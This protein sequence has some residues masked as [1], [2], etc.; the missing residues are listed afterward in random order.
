MRPFRGRRASTPAFWGSRGPQDEERTRGKGTGC[1]ASSAGSGGKASSCGGGPHEAER[2]RGASTGRAGGAERSRRPEARGGG[3]SMLARSSCASCSRASSSTADREHLPPDLE[4]QAAAVAPGPGCGAGE[5]GASLRLMAATTSSTKLKGHGVS[6]SSILA[7][8]CHAADT[9]ADAITGES[10]SGGD[11]AAEV[12]ALPN[13]RFFWQVPWPTNL[14]GDGVLG[15]T[16]ATKPTSGKR[17]VGVRSTSGSVQL[18]EGLPELLREAAA[19]TGAGCCS[20][21]RC[22]VLRLRVSSRCKKSKSSGAL[23]SR[24][25]EAGEQIA[26]TAG[27]PAPLQR[28]GPVCMAFM[29]AAVGTGAGATPPLV[30]SGA[31][32]LWSSLSRFSLLSTLLL[33]PPFLSPEAGGGQAASLLTGASLSLTLLLLL[34]PPFWSTTALGSTM[35]CAALGVPTPFLPMGPSG[36]P[37]SPRSNTSSPRPS[38]ARCGARHVNSESVDQRAPK[39]PAGVAAPAWHS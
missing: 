28:L 38:C 1:L 29:I 23:G 30:C 11:P 14:P 13:E 4:G 26:N 16:E 6:S 7:G 15:A 9:V 12:L 31:G 3:R 20:R 2:P 8:F 39:K 34:L 10:A 33:L 19:T 24:G 21:S 27:A 18:S 36:I 17:A 32:I 37:V 22:N 5:S 35:S 25:G